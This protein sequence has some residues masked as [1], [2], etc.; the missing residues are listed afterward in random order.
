[1]RIDPRATLEADMIFRTHVPAPPL[2]HYVR[3]L[4]Y[5][6]GFD[7][8]HALDRFLPDGNT[9]IIFD[10]SD[11]PQYIHDNDTLAEIQV[12]REAWVSGVRTR[13]ITIPSGRGSRMLVV[14]FEKGRAHPFY[15]FPMSELTDRVADADLVFGSAVRVL[16]DQLRESASI[17][18]MFALVE[19][20][21]LMQAPDG[22]HADAASRCVEYAVS[23]LMKSPDHSSLGQLSGE[24]GYS[25]K[26]FIDLF[27]RQVGVSPKQYFRITRFQHAVLTIERGSAVH[28]SGLARETGFYD[29]AH[30][31]HDFKT[32]SGFT[33]EE[34]LRRKTDML[35]YI[36]VG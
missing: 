16:R 26:H 14:A 11:L 24:I 36:P 35:N 22:L 19:A 7:P 10:L 33:P 21:L 8:V 12:C 9:E 1:L 25:Q 31:I 30:F 17:E 18:R 6:E 34:Y 32:F 23:R 20:F 29:Q 15:R 5:Y 28:W 3:H 4:F 27:K 13:P 2:D